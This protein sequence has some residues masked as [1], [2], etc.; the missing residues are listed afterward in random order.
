MKIIVDGENILELSEIQLKVLCDEIF[1]SELR[2]DLKRR[3]KWILLHKYEN[4]FERLK[5]EWEPKMLANDVQSFPAN[6]EEFAKLVF[7]QPNYKD[8]EQRRAEGENRS[9]NVDNAT[10]L[11]IS[12]NGSIH[13]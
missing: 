11:P 8:A 6:K 1:K 7:S 3:V 4:C 5:K 10:D 9:V 2:K 12:K 13:G